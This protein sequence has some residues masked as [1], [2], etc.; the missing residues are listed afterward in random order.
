MH[1]MKHRALVG[2]SAAA[3][4]SAASATVSTQSGARDAF[5]RVNGLSLHYVDWGGKGEPLIFLTGAGASAREFDSLA[6]S[7]TDRLHVLGLTRRGQAQSEAPASGYDTDTLVED[8]RCFI[9]AMGFSRVTLAGVSMAGNELTRFAGR[10]PERVSGLVYLDAAYDQASRRRLQDDPRTRYPIALTMPSGPLGELMKEAQQSDPD[11][12]RVAVPSLGFFV[13]YDRMPYDASGV[14]APMRQT[15][16]RLWREVGAPMQRKEI[17]RFRRD[18]SNERVVE[19][20]RTTHGT[21]MHDAASRRVI[22]R[23]MRRFLLGAS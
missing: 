20:R 9:D 13:I 22:I 14:D 11:Y 4:I 23:E 15:L 6:P 18:L 19:L 12:T 16:E 2:L 1:N 21:F 3:I 8:I 5:V 7:F 17:A 10:Y